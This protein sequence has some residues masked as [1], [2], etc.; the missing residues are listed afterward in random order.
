MTSGYVL[1]I[2]E[3]KSRIIAKFWFAASY[4]LTAWDL[5]PETYSLERSEF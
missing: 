5:L 1:R 3:G 2:T 4:A